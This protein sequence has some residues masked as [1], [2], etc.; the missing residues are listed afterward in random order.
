[1]HVERHREFSDAS[2]I[3]CISGASGVADTSAE[4]VEALCSTGDTGG[5]SDTR[6]TGE[7]ATQMEQETPQACCKPE[8]QV[9]VWM[10]Q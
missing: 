7:P 10:L 3:T 4:I 2:D 5:S 6:G 1:M 9:Y 8:V